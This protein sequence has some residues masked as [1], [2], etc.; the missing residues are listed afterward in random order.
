MGRKPKRYTAEELRRMSEEGRHTLDE[1][2]ASLPTPKKG[3]PYGNQNRTVHSLKAQILGPETVALMRKAKRAKL[4]LDDYEA[5]LTVRIGRASQIEDLS[6]SAQSLYLAAFKELRQVKLA[7]ATIAEIEQ[8]IKT[9][10]PTTL[11]LVTVDY[12][13]PTSTLTI[14]GV[15]YTSMQDPDGATVVRLDNGSWVP[16]LQSSDGTWELP[17]E[18]KQLPEHKTKRRLPTKG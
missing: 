2:I 18:P 7:R 8:R 10:A 14:A 15:E 13:A 4:T 12:A 11:E 5:L 9:P 6:P 17:P 16:V 3:A 1:V